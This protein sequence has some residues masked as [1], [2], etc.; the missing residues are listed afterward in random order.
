MRSVPL[1]ASTEHVRICAKNPFKWLFQECWLI[2]FITFF[3][4]SHF[5]TRVGNQT[6]KLD[7]NSIPNQNIFRIVEMSWNGFFHS[8]ISD[9]KSK[10]T[11]EISATFTVF[12]FSKKSVTKMDFLNISDF[13]K[14]SWTNENP[15]DPCLAFLKKIQCQHP[16]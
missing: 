8:K 7:S 10:L 14:N 5:S 1:Y 12:F 6:L 16:V 2:H 15:D 4:A 11:F 9:N 3:I 13:L